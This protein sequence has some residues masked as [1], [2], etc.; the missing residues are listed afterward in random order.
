[1][2]KSEYIWA[3]GDIHGYNQ[4]LQAVLNAISSYNNKKL[5]FVGDYIDRGPEP[6][7]VLDT[8]TNIKEEKVTLLGEH[9]FLL[10]NAIE[11][12]A[13]N[14]KAV[15]EWSKHGYENTLKA[16][17]AH[18]VESLKAKID[19][20]HLEF[21]NNLQLFHTETIGSGKKQLNLLFS[22]AGPFLDFSLEE[23]LKM[24]HYKDFRN[25]MNSKNIAIEDNCLN[26]DDR[27]LQKSLSIWDGYLLVH[28]HFRT[29]YR[30]NKNRL[31]YASKDKDY[32][33]DMS[34][35]PNPVYFPGGG[36]VAALCIDTGVDIGGKL[37]AV[38]FSEENID[39]NSGKMLLKVVQVDSS[40]RT[41]SFHPVTF[42]LTL[43]FTDE[44]S[45][46]AKL[47]KSLFHSK[48]KKAKPSGHQHHH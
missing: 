16:Y 26:N 23:Q 37:T 25:Y 44:I 7:D 2:A 5:I 29:Q 32:N 39:F 15:L 20:H 4:S 46:F 41:K 38:G 14:P 31:Q 13:S 34:D 24:Q 36:A 9:E 11:G 6:K 45:W 40:R 1:M 47:K 21:I 27:L 30:Q 3:I 42:E 33:Y 19:K 22:H 12:E 35:I 48:K 17:E 8:I 28:G 43:P 10:L 18:D